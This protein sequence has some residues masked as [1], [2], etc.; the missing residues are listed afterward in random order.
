M[1]YTVLENTETHS[2]DSLKEEFSLAVLLGFSSEQKWLP[3]K[4]F[5][6]DEG[7]KLFAKITDTDEYYPTKCEQE[8]FDTHGNEIVELIDGNKTNIIEL[9]AGDGRKT[10]ILLSEMFKQK[11]DFEYQP[12]D[13]S[14]EAIVG[15]SNSLKKEFPK[16]KHHGVVAQYIPGLNWLTE[17]NEGRNF[18]LFLG[19]N[20]GNFHTPDAIVF[21]RTL[22]NSMNDGDLL[23]IGFDLKKEIDVLLHAYNDSQGVTS[24]FNLNILTRINH[25]LGGNFNISN[26]R[27]FGTYNPLLG[28]MESYIVSMT[29]QTVRIEALEKD[30]HFAPFEPIHLEFSYK[31]L[32]REVKHL[33]D[34][35]GFEIVSSF[36]DSKNYFV[37]SI[38][39][40][41]KN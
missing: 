34:E 18:I 26:F 35:T 3:S 15:L 20:I 23:M 17:N 38:W 28:S 13:I 40:A 8:I 19:S 27:H 37:D 11:K 31:Y 30:F 33:A 2:Y 22:W 24:A 25:E 21:L 7:S 1:D 41:K 32:N 5:Y 9:G 6:D 4:F 16:L 10:K 29:D 39:R 36:K 14:A 12:I